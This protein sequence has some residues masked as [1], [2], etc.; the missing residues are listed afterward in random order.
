MVGCTIASDGNKLFTLKLNLNPDEL[1]FVQLSK[2]CFL[3]WTNFRQQDETWAEFTTT[4]VGVQLHTWVLYTS[5]KWPYLV[6]N[7]AQTSFR[8]SP[9]SF[10]TPRSYVPVFLENGMQHLTPT[11]SQPCYSRGEILAT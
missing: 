7:S 11:P 3:S 9:V 6:E 4:D 1:N 10:R 5:S 8:F 2:L